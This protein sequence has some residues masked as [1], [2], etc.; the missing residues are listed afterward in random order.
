M[1]SREKRQLK[2][3]FDCITPNVF[4]NICQREVVKIEDESEL[5]SE[6]NKKANKVEKSGRRTIAISSMVAVAACFLC[7]LLFGKNENVQ[8]RIILDINPSISIWLDNKEQVK[9]VEALNED[10]KEILDEFPEKKN[11]DETVIEI[12]DRLVEKKYLQQN[13]A[14][15]LVTYD[16]KNGVAPQEKVKKLV[17]GYLETENEQVTVIYQEI[18]AEEEEE[19]KAKEQGVSV[20][21]YHFIQKLE[22]ENKE[23]KAEELYDKNMEEIV[24]NANDKGV[25][26]KKSGTAGSKKAEKQE[27]QEKEVTEGDTK[28][29]VFEEEEETPIQEENEPTVEEEKRAPVSG[30]KPRKNQEASPTKKPQQEIENSE[31]TQ[32]PEE[33]PEVEQEEATPLPKIKKEKGNRNTNR[34]NQKRGEGNKRNNF[35]ISTNKYTLEKFPLK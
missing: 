17:E 15:V 23:I 12:L 13:K 31:V 24:K 3:G 20:G 14:S 10:G 8:N 35:E 1:Y 22:K 5:F 28:E 21:K 30:E 26:L 4:E 29:E 7:L 32:E 16:Y 19:K 2:T 34:Q 18:E 27:K 11:L 25:D 6:L 33:E 9:K